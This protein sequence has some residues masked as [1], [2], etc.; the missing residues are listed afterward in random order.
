MLKILLL[1]KQLERAKA[2]A[3]AHRAK[4]DIQQRRDALT[5]RKT[6]CEAAVAELSETATDEE[7]QVVYE[8]I[9]K[10]ET[11][12]AAIAADETAYADEQDTLDKAVTDIEAQ[13]S[14]LNEK[15][16]AAAKPAEA[17]KG[18]DT[19]MIN[20]Q[21]FFGLDAEQRSAFVS[22]EGVKTFL[23]DVRS[24]CR[25]MQTRGVTNAKLTVPD[26]MLDIVRDIVPQYSKL[27]AIVSMKAIAGTGRQNIMGTIPEA[28]WTE[29]SGALNELD[30]SLSQVT[31]DG[32]KVGGYI[33]ISN[34]LLEDSDLSL[35]AEIMAALAQA[36]GKALDRAILYGTGTKMPVGIATRLAQTSEPA[37]W[38][39]SMPAWTD[40]HIANVVTINID[41]NTGATFFSALIEK[42]AIA[43]PNYTDG[44]ATWIMNRTTHITLQRKA[45]AFDAAAALLAGVNN[46]MPIIGG[47]IIELEMVGDN[48][49][50]GG[51]F[52]GYLLAQRAGADLA[53]SE[54]A[55]F[56]EEQTLIRGTARYDGFPFIPEAFVI[57]S[58]DNSS[59]ATSTTFRTDWADTEVGNLVVTAAAGA[60]NGDT[61]LTVSGTEASGT[62]LKYK[63]GSYASKLVAGQPVSG[64]S[65]LTSGTT[66]ITAV[67]G[68]DITV[69][70]LNAS[71]LVIK[72]GTVKSVAK[73]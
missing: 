30:M 23:G 61:V 6:R 49:I 44:T 52:N 5:E 48:E 43:K 37:S 46:E 66:Q 42:L 13:I 47:K 21:K 32:Y 9:S 17:K 40:L 57:V 15:A 62:T 2:S 71:R 22:N 10:I 14:D 4:T 54:H 29:V 56:V 36:I 68:K 39:S 24:M 16:R 41:G 11:E 8:E 19:K 67:T 60:A 51:Y 27:M 12:T 33:A 1:A 64:Y 18:A 25:G 20:R 63:L 3:E 55:R 65:A 38:T 73:A 26:I 31:V 53:Q 70:E 69:V 59:P 35:S 58:F 34:A 7:V 28:V 50:I 45:L 72:V